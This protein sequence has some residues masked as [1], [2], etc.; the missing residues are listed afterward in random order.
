MIRFLYKNI[1]NDIDCCAYINT[2]DLRN[3][4]KRSNSTFCIYSGNYFHNLENVNFDNLK[5]ILTREEM[6]ILCNHTNEDIS[7][8]ITKLESDEN[9]K[10]FLEILEEEKTVL[11]NEFDLTKEE[12]DELFLSCPYE[13]R[14]RGIVASVFS[15][16]YDL[17]YDFATSI[18]LFSNKMDEEFW[19]DYIDFTRVG[20]TRLITDSGYIKLNS[21][22][23]VYLNI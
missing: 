20:E 2:D 8:I 3:K 18:G 15:D 7:E 1:M 9:D 11:M 12:V 5:T 10:L 23:I 21:G 17:G 22:K 4:L 14:D 16:E 6:N 19:R 13:Y